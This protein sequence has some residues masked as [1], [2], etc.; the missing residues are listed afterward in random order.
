MEFDI[1]V[2]LQEKVPAASV[3][4]SIERSSKDLIESVEL[5]DIYRG[6]GLGEKEKALAYHVI[7]RAKDR[8]LNDEEMA[9]VQKKVFQN[10]EKL[11]GKI[12]GK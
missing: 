12:R 3:Q 11:G 8:T 4:D 6:Q 7:M 1:S 2:V 10:L 9:Q 5:F